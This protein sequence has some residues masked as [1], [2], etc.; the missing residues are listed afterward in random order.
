MSQGN[1]ESN[2]SENRVFPPSEQ[3]KHANQLSKATLDTLYKE[4]AEDHESF[5]AK[6][7]RELIDWQQEFSITLDASNAPFYRWFPDGRLN[8]SYNCID[9]HLAQH[10]DKTA[11]HDR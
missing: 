6:Q 2:L 5:W 4:A 7:A 10:A 9:R 11:I 1:I 8:V 3:F